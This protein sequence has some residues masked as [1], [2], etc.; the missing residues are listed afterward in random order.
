M[1]AIIN[2]RVTLV[3]TNAMTE[4][5]RGIDQGPISNR[6]SCL[7]N[8]MCNKTRLLRSKQSSICRSDVNSTEVWLQNVETT[9]RANACHAKGFLPDWKPPA[10][11]KE[12]D[13]KHICKHPWCKFVPCHKP[14][15]YRGHEGRS[16]MSN[17]IAQKVPLKKALQSK[18]GLGKRQYSSEEEEEEY[19][20]PAEVFTEESPL[21]KT[22]SGTKKLHITESKIL[23]TAL[24]RKPR[25]GPEYQAELPA[26]SR[27]KSLDPKQP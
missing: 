22:V 15:C 20:V 16:R 3:L 25:I 21:P 27:P 24:P 2:I 19:P 9:A 6:P 1:A 7:S 11:L 5:D 26:F 23:G 13:M 17:E 12:T 14:L 10:T 8:V 18:K 4:G